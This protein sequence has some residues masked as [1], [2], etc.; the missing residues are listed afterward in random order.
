MENQ[1]YNL[2]AAYGA[3]MDEMKESKSAK[4]FGDFNIFGIV[5]ADLD[6]PC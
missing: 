3:V 6:P 4:N 5:Y 1:T 2:L